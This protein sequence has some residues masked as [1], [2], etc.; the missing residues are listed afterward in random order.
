MNQGKYVF[1]QII[2]L[3]STTS[4]KSCVDRYKGDFKTKHFS[5]WKQYLCMAF[6]QLTHR[7]SLSDTVLCL[8][9]NGSK[10]YHLGIGM[11]FSKSTLAK[12]NENR[13]FRIYLDLAMLLIGEAKKLYL[14]DNELEVNLKSNVFAIDATTIDM[15]LSVFSWAKF[16]STK[17]GIKLHTQLDLKTSIPEFIEITN[18]AVHEVN[19]MDLIKYQT[20]SFYVLDRGYTDFE[21]LYR[22]HL[23]EA[24]YIIRAKD[25]LH[26]NRISST[27]PNKTMGVI[28]DQEISLNN[29]YA[30]KEYPEN[31]RRIKFYDKEN[32]RTFVFLTNN[33]ELKATDIAQLYK[34]RWKIE[35]FF[36]W[37]KQHLKIKSFWGRSENAVKTQIWIAIGTYALIAIAKKKLKLKQSLYE[38]LQ[39]V[40]ICSL[41]KTPI[42][43]LFSNTIKQNLKGENPNQLNI[44]E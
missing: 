40:S 4:F 34:H 26:F 31:L 35:L 17:A 21:R 12:A 8:S 6:G 39:L 23:N 13:N 29:F 15:C 43:E 38:I 30:L 27:Y 25:N 9:A 41:D 14:K 16:R 5:C 24:F 7:E 44:F 10:L 1:S 2:S 11:A 28:C 37:I 18:A 36:K 19:V 3:I 22:I 33:W 32:D 20:D 42:R